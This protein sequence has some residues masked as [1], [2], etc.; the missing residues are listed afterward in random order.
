M[1]VGDT[2]GQSDKLLKDQLDLIVKRRNQIA[3]EADIEPEYY[4]RRPIDEATI[5]TAIDFIERIVQAIHTL[6]TS[7]KP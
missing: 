4:T 3:H 7:P 1:D 6:L 2:V 5:T